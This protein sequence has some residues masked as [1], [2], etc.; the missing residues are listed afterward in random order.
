MHCTGVL[1]IDMSATHI[2]TYR[3]N[4]FVL[5]P[6]LVRKPSLPVRRNRKN[7]YSGRKPKHNQNQVDRNHAV[8]QAEGKIE[9]PHRTNAIKHKTRQTECRLRNYDARAF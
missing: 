9:K 8:H 6:N 4:A 7:Y 2:S 1:S 3:E 5:S